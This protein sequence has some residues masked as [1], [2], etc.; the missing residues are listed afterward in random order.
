MFA[1]VATIESANKIKNG[2][3]LKLS[4]QQI[5][6]CTAEKCGGGTLQEAFKYVQ[7]NGGIA[8]EEEYGAYTAKAGS[9]H[10]GNVRK[11]VRIQTYD[12]LPREN[13]TALAEKVVQQPVA[14]LFD[15]HDPAFAYYK[16]GIYSGGQPRT[17]YV[18]NHAMAIVGYGKNE[19]TGQKYWIAKNSW[20]TGWGDGG[21][22][23]IA[24]D[25]PDKPQGVQGLVAKYPW[26][27]IV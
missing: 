5:V 3:L 27:P 20:G 8:T 17:R 26:Y 16:G 18:L 10:A 24:K 14:V 15:A 22:V 11:A 7:K 1:S 21:Y 2:D 12:F 13:E 4:E 6:D 9:C 25:M 19:S 23:Y